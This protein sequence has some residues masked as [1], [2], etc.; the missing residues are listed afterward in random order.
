MLIF[1]KWTSGVI[2]IH[3]VTH[4]AF[5]KSE[6]PMYS[7]KL[8]QKVSLRV[9]YNFVH[10]EIEIFYSFLKNNSAIILVLKKL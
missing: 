8:L 4:N 10:F 3:N 6:L 7:I 5:F 9:S 1:P 2:Q